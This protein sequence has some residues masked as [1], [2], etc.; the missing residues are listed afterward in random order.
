MVE[1]AM[2]PCACTADHNLCAPRGSLFSTGQRL[3]ELASV[4][5]V[6]AVSSD[7]RKNARLRAGRR[8]S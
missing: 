4:L 6:Q 1:Y 2:R 3:L 7:S 5:P 8:S